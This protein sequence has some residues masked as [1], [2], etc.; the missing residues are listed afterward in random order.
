MKQDIQQILDKHELWL[1]TNHAEGERAN[2][3]GSDLSDADLGHADLRCAN[4]SGSDLSGSDLR[5]ANL[6][7][8]NLSGS[9][10]RYANLK[11]ANLKGANISGSVFW[12]IIGNMGSIKSLFLETYPIAYTSKTLQ[13]GCEKHYIEAWESFTDRQILNMDGKC[14]LV[15]W[16]KYKGLIF[17]TIKLSPANDNVTEH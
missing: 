8:A 16:K 9:D 7:C 3:S 5:Y 15:F 6:R 14:A 4:L 11:G 1:K 13:I 12:G 17:E 10:L 2:L